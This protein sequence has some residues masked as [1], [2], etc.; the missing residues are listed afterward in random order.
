MLIGR[1]SPQCA[2]AKAAE[3]MAITL[4]AVALTQFCIIILI[5]DA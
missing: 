5:G 2:K 3:E 1:V 4:Q